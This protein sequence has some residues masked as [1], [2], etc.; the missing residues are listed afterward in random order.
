MKYG[1][2][3]S[4]CS[5]SEFASAARVLNGALRINPWNTEE[6][7]EQLERC[8]NMSASER[9]SRRARDLHFVEQVRSPAS[10]RLL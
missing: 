10:P 9:S 2:S 3:A 5:L 4:A 7:T 8:V 1:E 6:C